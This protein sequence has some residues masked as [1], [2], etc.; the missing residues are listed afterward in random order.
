VNQKQAQMLDILSRTHSLS[1]AAVE[2]GTSQPR[3]TQQLKGCEQE[4]GV[5]LFHRSPR[6][7]LL[8]EAGQTFLPYARQIV[9]TFQQAQEALSSLSEG[10]A[11]RLRLGASITASHQLVPE[12]LL[13][14]HKRYPEVLVTVTRV[15]PKDLVKG[16]E[17]G[18]F[19][20]CFG[21][22]LPETALFM[23]EEFF[24]TDLVGLSSAAS[25][26]ARRT[27]LAAFCRKPLVLVTRSCDTRILLDDALRRAQVKPRVVLEADDVTTVLAVVRAGVAN[28][29]LPR[30]LAPSSRT[31]LISDFTDLIIEIHG[32]LLYPRN[33]TTEARKFIQL[34]QEQVRPSAH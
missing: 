22:E 13:L 29:I 19:D 28:T 10:K 20:V 18:R 25:K 9:S 11:N 21:L 3:L 17:E 6:G 7:L 27:S 1:E 5:E 23:R 8:S 2:M 32:M 34:M 15:V 26:P 33:C 24:K 16:L 31:L 4:L 12:N 30:T 14:F